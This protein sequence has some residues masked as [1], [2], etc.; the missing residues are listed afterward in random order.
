MSAL[1]QTIKRQQAAADPLQSAFVSANAGAGKTRVLTNRV[2]RLLLAD[3]PPDRILCITFT[4]AAAAEM[5]S[6]LFEMLGA[7][8]LADDDDLNEALDALEGRAANGSRETAR[9]GDALIKARRLFARALETPGGLKIQTIHSFCE[10]VLRRF[11]LEA[12][13][14]PGFRVME[15]AD[16]FSLK[17]AAL[18]QLAQR[19]LNDDALGAMIDRLSAVRFKGDL[20]SALMSSARGM[21]DTQEIAAVIR[22]ALQLDEDIDADDLRDGF[23]AQIDADQWAG[24]S[25]AMAQGGANA[26]K[27]NALPM[28]AY[29]R[30]RDRAEKWRALETLFLT[31]AGDPRKKFG[32]KKTE[33]AA[34]G[35]GDYLLSLQ[36]QF[37]TYQDK[38]A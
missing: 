12:G 28:E 14:P 30:A 3:A 23:F 25:A 20:R 31:A 2:A 27:H 16:A 35:A 1:V 4:K 7:W 21:S 10:S 33:A 36:E 5:A 29:G 32:D 19:A 11:P 24:I 34:P 22:N 9:D 6:R 38:L 18:G 8:S 17:E 13:L 37:I 15:E 26:K